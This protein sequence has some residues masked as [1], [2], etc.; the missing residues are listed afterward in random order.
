MV[1]Y[2]Q[3]PGNVAVLVDEKETA[4]ESGGDQVGITVFGYRVQVRV[5]VGGGL[6]RPLT[7]EREFVVGKRDLG[8]MLDGTPAEENIVGLDVDFVEET[9][10]HPAVFGS[11]N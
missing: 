5:F 1:T 9:V 11:A 2:V 10:L 4:H 6:I 3:M 7:I 8:E